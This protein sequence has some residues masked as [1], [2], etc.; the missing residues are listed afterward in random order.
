[1]TGRISVL[2]ADDEVII[3]RKVYMMLAD[4]FHLGQAA[5]AQAVRD[6]DLKKYDAILLDIVFPDG[7]GI[8]LCREIKKQ[9]P[10]FTVVMSS[11]M[12][13]VD[14]WNQAFQAGADGY[15]EKR[16]L[17]ALD[18]RKIQL[19]IENL[20]ERNELRRQV[21][22]THRRQAELMS[23]LSHDV[24]APFQ[25]L[26]G[27]IELLKKS[28]IPVGAAQNV[29]TLYNCAKD[30]LAFI[31]SLL[32]ILRLESGMTELRLFP[33]DVNLPVSQSVQGLRILASAKKISLEVNLQP[34][35]PKVLGDIG[36]TCQLMNNLVSNAIKFTPGGGTVTVTTAGADQNGVPGVKIAVA[37]TGVGISPSDS[38][39]IFQRFRR[40][41]DR[42]TEGET[43]TG[44]GLSICKEIVQLHGGTLEV[45]SQIS[46]GSVFVVWLPSE[47]AETRGCSREPVPE[48]PLRGQLTK[49]SIA[50]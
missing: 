9:D 22:E 33:M 2:I 14:A 32:E 26:L 49:R 13:S 1:M 50:C 23:V 6:E 29:E 18:P 42:G 35:L 11:S 37:D 10:H 17:L 43:G 30:Q 47:T 12:E 45:H 46:K 34:G 4:K 38:G 8:D 40:G 48:K 36:K 7:N 39:K 21:E 19:M 41:R 25:A 20:V 31:N 44:L 27:T 15:L 5:T 24:R 16:E 3:R 28:R